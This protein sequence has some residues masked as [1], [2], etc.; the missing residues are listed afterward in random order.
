MQE[1]MIS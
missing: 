1:L